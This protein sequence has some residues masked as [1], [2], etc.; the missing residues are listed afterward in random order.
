M[1]AGASALA[2]AAVVARVPGDGSARLQPV[3][4][5]S[6]LPIKQM[7]VLFCLL[8]ELLVV[9]VSILLSSELKEEATK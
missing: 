5:V 7:K 9:M 2:F 1:V 8:I 6:P 4:V 3:V